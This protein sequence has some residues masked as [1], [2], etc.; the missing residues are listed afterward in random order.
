MSLKYKPDISQT[1]DTGG[2][3]VVYHFRY[4]CFYILIRMKKYLN[5]III[6][7]MID[8]N[9]HLVYLVINLYHYVVQISI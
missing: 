7:F 1:E 6:R 5:I 2:E 4:R 8:P 3:S 9:Y